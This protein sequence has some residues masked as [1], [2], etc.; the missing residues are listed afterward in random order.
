MVVGAILP[1]TAPRLPGSQASRLPGSQAPTALPTSL[2]PDSVASP[3]LACLICACELPLGLETDVDCERRV[4]P[5]PSGTSSALHAASQ[6]SCSNPITNH[7]PRSDGECA[8]RCTLPP[9][10]LCTIVDH[11]PSRILDESMMAYVVCC[12]LEFRCR[13]NAPHLANLSRGRNL[14]ATATTS[15]SS[16]C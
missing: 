4:I 10:A 7:K 15:A 5:T 14:S 13:S 9:I 1:P 2:M 16:G 6:S 12:L 3:R 8:V 11:G